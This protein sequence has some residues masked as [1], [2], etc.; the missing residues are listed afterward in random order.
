MIYSHRYSWSYDIFAIEKLPE[1]L[2]GER[3][4]SF[5]RS[6]SEAVFV[7]SFVAFGV[8]AMEAL[9]VMSLEFFENVLDILALTYTNYTAKSI[10]FDLASR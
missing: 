9:L 3:M 5:S 4:G 8:P 7:T 10:A 1:E 6:S 2:V